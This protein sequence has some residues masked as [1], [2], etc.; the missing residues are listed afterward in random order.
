MI[1]EEVEEYLRS[2]NLTHKFVLDIVDDYTSRLCKNCKWYKEDICCNGDSP[3]CAEFVN[4]TYGC[5]F[6]NRKDNVCGN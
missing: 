6:F 3:L 5:V 4:D 2:G 1:R